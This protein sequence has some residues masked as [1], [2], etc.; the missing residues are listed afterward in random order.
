[1]SCML[2][3]PASCGSMQRDDI[4]PR[5]ADSACCQPTLSCTGVVLSSSSLLTCMGCMPIPPVNAA[6][7][8]PLRCA[9]GG[10]GAGLWCA[11]WC[12]CSHSVKI[13]HL[14]DCFANH[15]GFSLHI[16]A[17]RHGLL[18]HECNQRREEGFRE[19]RAARLCQCWRV[20][21]RMHLLP[22]HTRTGAPQAMW[23]PC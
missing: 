23:R 12:T 11:C 2:T 17:R 6:C 19:Y 9:G 18:M 8:E 10:G 5:E 21:A 4:R 7:W 14:N 22:L 15:N 13:E 20:T 16:S 3:V 1:M